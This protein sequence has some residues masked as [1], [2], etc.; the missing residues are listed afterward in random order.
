M[1]I[2]SLTKQRRPWLLFYLQESTDS[3]ELGFRIAQELLEDEDVYST[4]CIRSG[5][6]VEVTHILSLRK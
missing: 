2:Q 5:K 3:H 1:F 6:N 4:P